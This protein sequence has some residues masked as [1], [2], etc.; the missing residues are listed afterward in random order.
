MEGNEPSTSYNSTDVQTI[1][2]NTPQSIDTRDKV[3][4]E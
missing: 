1:L 4:N 3:S 2:S